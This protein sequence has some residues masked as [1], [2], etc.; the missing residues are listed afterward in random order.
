[1]NCI[2]CIELSKLNIYGGGQY[3]LLF[4]FKSVCQNTELWFIHVVVYIQEITAYEYFT[5]FLIYLLKL[6]F[7]WRQLLLTVHYLFTACSLLRL[8]AK[9]KKNPRTQPSSKVCQVQQ[10]RGLKSGQ[11]HPEGACL[12]CPVHL[13]SY[14]SPL[15]ARSG[16]SAVAV[17]RSL[18]G[19]VLMESD[20][21]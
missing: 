2:N 14:S 1:M 3:R 7:S 16:C 15:G 5:N 20:W 8:Y 17:W 19:D 9:K 10:Y 11:S 13:N 18:C 6:Y 21:T 4:L 12:W